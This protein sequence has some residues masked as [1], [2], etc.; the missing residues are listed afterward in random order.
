MEKIIAAT[1]NKG[2]IREI[3]A[4]TEKLGISVIPRDEA[5]VPEDFDTDE[6]GS[7]FEE[8]SEMKARDI[9]EM[10]GIAAV[11][12]DSGLVVDALGGEPGVYSARYA[13]E[14]HNDAAN[15]KKILEKLS[16]VPDEARTA[17]FVCVVTLAMPGG[18]TLQAR[19][20]VEGKIIE[21]ER[22]ENGFGYDPIFIPDGYDRT[23]A[24]MSAEEKNGISHRANALAALA[25]LLEKRG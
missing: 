1:K 12:D 10:T 5:G 13:G 6:T 25:E 22:G 16:G 23:F 11:A 18:E 7:T 15:R 8:N 17:R 4:I 2:K 20:T 21:E 19:G 3:N 24:Q 9:L 14:E